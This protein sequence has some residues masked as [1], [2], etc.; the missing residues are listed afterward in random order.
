MQGRK[1]DQTIVDL[2]IQ[3]SKEG[4]KPQAIAKALEMPSSSVYN[5]L[6]RYGLHERKPGKKKTKKPVA[7]VKCPKCGATGHP[8]GARFCFKCGADIRTEGDILIEQMTDMYDVINMLPAVQAD[9]LIALINTTTDYIR[10][11]K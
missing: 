3:A 9:K 5:I 8:T 2:I 7:K 4:E 11:H 6:E 1:I 10:R